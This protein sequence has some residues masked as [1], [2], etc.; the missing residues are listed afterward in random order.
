MKISDYAAARIADPSRGFFREWLVM[1]WG[2]WA[3]MV[4]PE[5]FRVAD[6]EEEIELG[7]KGGMVRH[8]LR[9]LVMIVAGVARVIVGVLGSAW[10][11]VL[12]LLSPLL[13]LVM[14][15]AAH[16]LARR[17]MRRR[18]KLLAEARAG[19]SNHN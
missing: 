11:L 18:A 8:A 10:L 7:T 16:I 12:L 5:T 4:K 13:L 17:S 19:M 3:L 2:I 15:L 14:R 1:V 6:L 9:G